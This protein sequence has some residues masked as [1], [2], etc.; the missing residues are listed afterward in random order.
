VVRSLSRIWIDWSFA[1]SFARVLI[2]Q[3]RHEVPT[4]GS[5]TGYC[6]QPLYVAPLHAHSQTLQTDRPWP[7]TVA[8]TSSALISYRTGRDDDI[9]LGWEVS[10]K[11]ASPSSGNVY[12]QIDAPT[13]YTWV[14]IG[15]GDSMRNAKVFLMYQDGEGNVTLSTRDGRHHTMPIYAEKSNVKLLE[16]SKV[17]DGRMVANVLCS[18]CESLDLEGTNS[19]V[20][21]WLRGDPLYSASPEAQITQHD[22][23]AILNVD[24]QTA[25]TIPDQNPFL[26]AATGE[27]N[28]GAVTVLYEE[29]PTLSAIATAH[30]VIMIIVFAGLYPIGALLMPLFNQWFL[31]SA[32]QLIAFLLMWVGVGLGGEVARKNN[33]VS[34]PQEFQYN[35]KIF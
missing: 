31:H 30:G 18:E 15:V 22:E 17:E 10:R 25:T 12:L 34:V 6:R 32:S 19:W 8:A 5:D 7:H 2:C 26:S 9:R 27:T 29:T 21:A 4:N 24:F 13:T 20:A 11:G 16:G 3:E 1:A 23:K 28:W 35:E 14:G 33:L